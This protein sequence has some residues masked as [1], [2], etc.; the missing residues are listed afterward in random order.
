MSPIYAST[1]TTHLLLS[2]FIFDNNIA[3][4]RIYLLRKYGDVLRKVY[5]RPNKPKLLVPRWIWCGS[6]SRPNI[7]FITDCIGQF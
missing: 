5:H 7:I 4:Y 1:F 2:T 6:W 3:S